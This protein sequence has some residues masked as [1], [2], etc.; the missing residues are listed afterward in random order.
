[1]AKKLVLVAGNIG[2]GK[3]SLTEKLGGRLNWRT[4]FESVADNPYLA[5]F[6]SDMRTWAFHL[7]IYFLGHRAEQHL[8]L[9][10]SSQS[11]IA[12]RSIY[13]DLHIFSRASFTLGNV[14]ERDYHTYQK[15]YEIVVR[16]LPGPDLLL[17]LEAP[18]DVL[19]GRI[20]QRG[21]AIETSLTGEYLSLL[22]RYYHE[23]IESYDLSPVLRI[24]SDD[25]DFVHKPQHLDIVIGRMQEF[26]EGK[27]EL[28]F[29]KE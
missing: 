13:E 14:A 5:D 11:A 21:R 8:A 26:M 7:Q 29:P 17:Y 1:M 27:E 12:D 19:M 25:L 20:R 10:Q 4:S 28:F 2:S 23:W 3:T 18:V 16:N 15:I 24:H 22:D 9:A 6:Y